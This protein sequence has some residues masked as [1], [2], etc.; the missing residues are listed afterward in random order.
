MSLSYKWLEASQLLRFTASRIR[1]SL[2]PSLVGLKA[3]SYICVC[4][5]VG[6]HKWISHQIDQITTHKTADTTSNRHFMTLHDMF[7]RSLLCDDPWPWALASSTMTFELDLY[8]LG[9]SFNNH[10]HT[11]KDVPLQQPKPI[12]LVPHCVTLHS[13]YN[14]STFKK[15]TSTTCP[16]PHKG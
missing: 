4:H 8:H 5:E 13:W 9:F 6:N 11:E 2:A 12:R 15:T 3:G 10:G 7:T 14:C 16:L 1:H